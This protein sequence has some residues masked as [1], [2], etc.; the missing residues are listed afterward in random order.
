MIKTFVTHSDI[1]KEQP[2]LQD[3]LQSSQVSF[4]EA[5][6]SAYSEMLLDLKNKKY[7]L[8]KL[9]VPLTISTSDAVTGTP[10][11]LSD[12]SP[13]DFVNY[14]IFVIEMLVNAEGDDY[15]FELQGSDD[16]DTWIKVATQYANEVGVYS[17]ILYDYYKFYRV[18]ISPTSESVTSNAL[19]YSASLVES[20]YFYMHLYKSMESI[21]ATLGRRIDDFWESKA[22]F[23]RNKYNGLLQTGVFY[24]DQDDDKL[25]SSTDSNID[26]RT[27]RI[28][29]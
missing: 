24:F 28:K 8:R 23:Y 12:T 13:E 11:Y 7:N 27:I 17:T 21:Y 18:Q 14:S 2:S 6:A 4:D 5:I 25:I 1:V 19:T 22:I 29:L 16:E 9:G 15:T 20:V 26:T 3:R 10:P